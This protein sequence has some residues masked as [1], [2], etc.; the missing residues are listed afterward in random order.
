MEKGTNERASELNAF[1]GAREPNRAANLLVCRSATA[2]GEQCGIGQNARLRYRYQTIVA[3]AVRIDDRSALRLVLQCIALDERAV[4][5][6]R[7]IRSI[8][9]QVL[10]RVV[11]GRNLRAD[12][13][14]ISD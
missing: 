10:Q 2:C 13:V 3:V 6:S 12:C 14:L 9:L 11:L 7:L 1:Q 4:T 8:I 5:V